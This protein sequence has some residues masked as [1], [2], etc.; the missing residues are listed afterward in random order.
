[1]SKAR[2]ACR[3]CCAIGQ[4]TQVFTVRDNREMTQIS[5]DVGCVQLRHFIS[6]I[7][8]IDEFPQANITPFMVSEVGYVM[9]A[10]CPL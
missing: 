1:M 4:N 3:K 7:A 2:R 8:G 9:Q 10:F 6:C 5:S